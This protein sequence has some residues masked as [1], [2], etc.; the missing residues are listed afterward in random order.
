MILPNLLRGQIFNHFANSCPKQ[1]QEAYKHEAS[2]KRKY[3][4]RIK[5]RKELFQ[6]LVFATTGAGPS[7][8]KIITRLSVKL[9]NKTSESYADVG[10]IRMKV[11]FALLR[12]SIFCIRGFRSLKRTVTKT[13]SSMSTIVEEGRLTSFQ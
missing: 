13:K 1:I 7:A 6:A 2:K 8:S 12:S 3:E 9:G 10:F 4:Q 5:Y 11:S